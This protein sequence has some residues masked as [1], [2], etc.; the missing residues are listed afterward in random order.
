MNSQVM[1]I[2]EIGSVHDG[3]YG[4]ALKLIDAAAACG[5]GAVK[6]QTHIPEAETT[7]D[8]P[9]PGYFSA[10]DRFAYFQRTGFNLKQWC[11]IKQRCDE[12]GVVFLSS[13]FSEAAVELL[14]QVGMQMYKIPS[15]EVS[16]TPMLERIAGLGKPVLLSSGMSNWPELD[17]AVEIFTNRGV[18]LTLLQCSSVYP[19]PDESV[20]LNL[21]DEMRQRY[22]VPVG[23]SDHTLGAHACIAAVTLGAVVIEKHFTFSRLMYGSDAQHSMEPEEFSG[24]VASVRGV[25]KMLAS[26]VDKNAIKN[27]QGMKVIF[28]KSL[29]AAAALPAGTVLTRDHIEIKKPGTGIPAAMLERIIGA[30][31]ARD[32][33]ADELFALKDFTD[34]ES[35]FEDCPL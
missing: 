35:R 15:G 27:Y 2:A 24:L 16:N 25:E 21:L 19:C 28:E 22:R 23:F 8:A 7:R 13:P 17:R 11:A 18:E 14:E 33:A 6:F 1:I 34:G 26:P 3:S 20:G 4:N 30:T 5:A 9:A 31:L 29:V 12:R 10:E 32:V